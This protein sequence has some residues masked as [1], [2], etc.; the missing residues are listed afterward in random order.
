MRAHDYLL[1]Q[2]RIQEQMQERG[3]NTN[4]NVQKSNL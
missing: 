2:N 4:S 3:I 1:F